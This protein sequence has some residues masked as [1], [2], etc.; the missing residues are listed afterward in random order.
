MTLA[1]WIPASSKQAIIAFSVL[2]GFFSGAYV[3]LIA[4]LIVQISPLREIGIRTGL[5]FLL[6]S[7][8]GLTTGPMAGRVLGE[9]GWTGVKVFSGVLCLAG[10]TFILA[11]RIKLA[12][13]GLTTVF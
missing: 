5:V 9:S 10:T 2:F 7:I 12:G 1:L 3:S 8:G 13:P 6:A 11:A 4:A